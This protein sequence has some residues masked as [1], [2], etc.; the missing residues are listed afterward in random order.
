M[1]L[2]RFRLLFL[3]PV[4]LLGAC[5]TVPGDPRP[6]MP[7][8]EL[9][10]A[11]QIGDC[12]AAFDRMAAGAGTAADR[13]LQVSQLCLQTGDFAR[14]RQASGAFLADSPGHPD[15]DYA[16]YLHALAGF[17]EWS[18]LAGTDPEARIREGRAIA[19]EIAS[20]LRDRP[21]SPY[22]EELAPRMVR[23]REGIASAELDLAERARARGERSLARARAEYVLEHYPRTQAAADA[24]RLLMTMADE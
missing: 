15:S 12:R 5:A 20:Y 6:A 13:R 7:V 2:T 24:A 21:L 14:A 1:H 22:G 19:R 23:L 11:L 10:Q 4:L 9:S 16:A 17:G 8:D 18:R 3:A